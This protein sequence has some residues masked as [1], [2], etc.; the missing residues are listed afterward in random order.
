MFVLV[1]KLTESLS[2]TG[3]KLKLGGIN[4]TPYGEGYRTWV[5]GVEL[6]RRSIFGILNSEV[7]K[8]R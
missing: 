5:N 2:V 1:P 4:A 6:D 8:R 7:S 3:G